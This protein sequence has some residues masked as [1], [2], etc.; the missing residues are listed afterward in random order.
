MVWHTWW[1]W[2]N[3]L[4]FYIFIAICRVKFL[5]HEC[6]ILNLCRKGAYSVKL[7]TTVAICDI[8]YTLEIR[9]ML[10]KAA[11]TKR[12]ARYNLKNEAAGR[13]RFFSDEKIFTIQL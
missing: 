10:P 5:S 1:L 2:R 13:I 12:I 3:G 9:Q 11:V 8:S 7:R 6:G 4:E